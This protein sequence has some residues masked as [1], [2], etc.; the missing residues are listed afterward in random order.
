[1]AK[2]YD[3]C[4]HL[5]ELGVSGA[6]PDS[7]AVCTPTGSVSV[8]DLKVGDE[9][10]A[11]D[12]TKARVQSVERLEGERDVLKLSLKDKREVPCFE[13]SLCVVYRWTHRGPNRIL[14]PVMKAIYEITDHGM[15]YTWIKK[16]L[17][18]AYHYRSLVCLPVQYDEA[19]LPVDPYLV[20]VFLGDGNIG[21]YAKILT[22]SCHHVDVETV[23]HVAEIIGA[24]EYRRN[25]EYNYNWYFVM[26]EELR[27]NDRRK[28]FH[29]TDIFGDLPEIVHN[30]EDKFIPEVYKHASVD[31]RWALIQGLMDTDGTISAEKSDASDKKKAS[32]TFSSV[33]S[34][35]VHDMQ[36]VVWS[37]GIEANVSSH[38]RRGQA[39][40]SHG[41]V[42]HR[43]SVEHD[44]IIVCPN[45]VKDSF[46]CMGRKQDR[47]YRVADTEVRRDYRYQAMTDV[48]D[49]GYRDT[50]SRIVIDHDSHM[51]LAD[52]YMTVHDSE[53]HPLL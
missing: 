5:Q 48:V 29:V 16:S 37:L 46:F 6:I 31:Q 15:A 18:H 44:L 24:T 9:V 45:D 30:A 53:I 38:D 8:R 23:A 22:M 21:S 47:A 39:Q 20:G 19:V 33:S 41:K 7:L 13:D 11:C 49:A 10:F 28:Y 43:K 34:R 17:N 52:N 40:K 35:L 27:P 4:K 51:F 2:R 50:A 3:A 32:L 25:S 14:A 1:M 12:G 26:P 42:Y 36:E